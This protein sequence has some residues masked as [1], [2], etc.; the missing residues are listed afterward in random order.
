MVI[1]MGVRYIMKWVDLCVMLGHIPFLSFLE[2]GIK[3]DIVAR[4]RVSDV[5]QVGVEEV[6]VFQADGKHLVH[7]AGICG[8]MAVCTDKEGIVTIADEQ[9][10]VVVMVEEKIV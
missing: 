4:L 6:V 7:P 10:K 3:G 5:P 9:F 8:H 1:G 2:Q